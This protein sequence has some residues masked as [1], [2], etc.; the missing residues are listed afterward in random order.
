MD[1]CCDGARQECEPYR[2]RYEIENDKETAADLR[3]AGPFRRNEIV[4]VW[5]RQALPG[6]SL[7]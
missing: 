6:L 2:R 1:A 4:A 7:R 5:Q 3:G